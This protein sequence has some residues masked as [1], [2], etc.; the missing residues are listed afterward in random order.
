MSWCQTEL[1]G[2]HTDQDTGG[3]NGGQGRGPLIGISSGLKDMVGSLDRIKNPGDFTTGALVNDYN[4]Y[5]YYNSWQGRG[6]LPLNLFLIKS[7][8]NNS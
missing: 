7:N 3:L 8:V 4:Y 5:N 2:L 6:Y 1:P